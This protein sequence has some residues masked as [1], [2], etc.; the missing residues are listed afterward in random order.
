MKKSHEEAICS[1]CGWSGDTL[2]L[3][4]CP[5]CHRELIPLDTEKNEPAEVEKYPSKI[6]EETKVEDLDNLE[7]NV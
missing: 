4:N 1:N 2:G 3:T 6:L 7:G 5:D